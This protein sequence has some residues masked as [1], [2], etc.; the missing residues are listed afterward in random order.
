MSQSEQWAL[1]P[2]LDVMV[3]HSAFRNGQFPLLGRRHGMYGRLRSSSAKNLACEQGKLGSR[4]SA[5][6]TPFTATWRTRRLTALGVLFRAGLIAKNPLNPRVVYCTPQP[7]L[8]ASRPLALP[9]SSPGCETVPTVKAA[10][11][12][13]GMGG[14]P[15]IALSGATG[16]TRQRTVRLS[17]SALAGTGLTRRAGRNP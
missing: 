14:A 7:L 10:R 2:A 1:R 12:P 8:R 6:T 13:V 4:G 15:E 17:I 3:G 5:R 11:A 16:T 9:G